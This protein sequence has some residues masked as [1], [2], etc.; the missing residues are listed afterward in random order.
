ME[1]IKELRLRL[2]KMHNELSMQFRDVIL[3]IDKT[4]EKLDGE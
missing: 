3:N 4:L 2:R 1:E